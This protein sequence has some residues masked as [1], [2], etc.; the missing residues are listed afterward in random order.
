MNPTLAPQHSSD[1]AVTP[2]RDRRAAYAA[3]WLPWLNNSMTSRGGI[4]IRI[5]ILL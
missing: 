2:P 1:T 3:S 4:T 5:V